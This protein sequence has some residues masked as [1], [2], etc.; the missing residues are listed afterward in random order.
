LTAFLLACIFTTG[1]SSPA[2]QSPPRSIRVAAAADLKFALPDIIEALHSR[3]PD[4]GVSA[5]FGA[6]GDFFG[7]ISNG[8]PYDMFLSANVDYPQ[9]LIEQGH[10]V[11]DSLFVYAKGHLVAWVRNESAVDLSKTGIKAVIDPSVRKVAIANPRHAPYG[12][13]AEAA[14]KNAGLYEQIQSRLAFGENV[15]QTAQFVDTGAADVGLI[16]LSL[17]LSPP[18]RDRGRYVEIAAELYPPLEQAGVI[19][20]GC[21]DKDDARALRDFLT[22]E[23]G[24]SILR[25]FGFR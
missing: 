24:R 8:A 13:A 17:A 12:R 2:T 19:L 18:L 6:S 10:G 25:R 21:K 23:D 20:T 4:L 5:T 3:Q 15:A 9:K 11:K 1:C 16:A 14:L 22:S 7:Q